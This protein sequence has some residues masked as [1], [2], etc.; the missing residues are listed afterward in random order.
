MNIVPVSGIAD[1]RLHESHT[2]LALEGGNVHRRVE[3][4]LRGRGDVVG[5]FDIPAPESRAPSTTMDK[6]SMCVD[7]RYVD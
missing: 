4:R 3:R 7:C 5:S 6:M 1:G 2:V